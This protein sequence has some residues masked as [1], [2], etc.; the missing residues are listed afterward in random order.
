MHLEGGALIEDLEIDEAGPVIVRYSRRHDG[1]RAAFALC[2]VGNL[3][4]VHS[5][6]AATLGE[7]RRAVPAA[8]HY[9]L[10]HGTDG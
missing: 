1:W 7:A 5:L 6:E 2:A 10:G 9:L 3:A 8:V 4:V